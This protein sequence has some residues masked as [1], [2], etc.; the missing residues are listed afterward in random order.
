M[1][2][3]R[4][5]LWDDDSTPVFHHNVLVF[6]FFRNVE[7]VQELMGKTERVDIF[8]KTVPGVG[9]R[10]SSRIVRHECCVDPCGEEVYSNMA[11]RRQLSRS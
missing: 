10:D 7:H 8:N 5:R 4:G 9:L 1:F 3:S 6:A 2:K 11:V